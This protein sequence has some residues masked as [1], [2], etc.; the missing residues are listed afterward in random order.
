MLALYRCGRQAEALATYTEGR[1]LLV[2]Q[3]GIDPSKDLRDLEQRI[4]DQDPILDVV[5]RPARAREVPVGSTVLRSSVIA[6]PAHV[7]IGDESFA[8]ARGVTTIGRLPDRDIVLTD[9]GASRAHGEIRSTPDGFVLVDT[10][11]ANGTHV[12]GVRIREHRLGDGDVIRIGDTELV[13][14]VGAPLPS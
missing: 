12:G 7:L 2:E 11:S 13:F 3:L 5:G 9:P 8:L 1:E 6:A 4:L 14:V 10:A